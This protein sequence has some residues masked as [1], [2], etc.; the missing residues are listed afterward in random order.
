MSKS[1]EKTNESSPLKTFG[2]S[3]MLAHSIQCS[4]RRGVFA[5]VQ[6][7]KAVGGVSMSREHS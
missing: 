4:G 1:S 5:M 6:M 2:H 7:G 3:S